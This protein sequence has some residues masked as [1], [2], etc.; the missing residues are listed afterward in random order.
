MNYP[1]LYEFYFSLFPN[2]HTIKCTFMIP[3]GQLGYWMWEM[4]PVKIQR[5]R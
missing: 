1:A 3:Q 2:F 4:R 5:V